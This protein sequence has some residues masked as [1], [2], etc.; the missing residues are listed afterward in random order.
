MTESEK[1]CATCAN[2]REPRDGGVCRTCNVNEMFAC[3]YKEDSAVTAYKKYLE[4]VNRNI[5]TT[6]K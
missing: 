1:M 5:V 3:R 2:R 4:K 6:L